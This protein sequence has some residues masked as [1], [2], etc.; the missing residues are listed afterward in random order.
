[1]EQFPEDDV[2][3]KDEDAHSAPLEGVPEL[4]KQPIESS[5]EGLGETPFSPLKQKLLDGLGAVL[6]G[7]LVP[8]YKVVE[9]VLDAVGVNTGRESHADHERIKTDYESFEKLSEETGEFFSDLI[10]KGLRKPEGDKVSR[11]LRFPVNHSRLAQDNEMIPHSLVSNRETWKKEYRENKKKILENTLFGE[12]K[13]YESAV[14]ESEISEGSVLQERSGA[15]YQGGDTNLLHE[16]VRNEIDKERNRNEARA[17]LILQNVATGESLSFDSL[18]PYGW[19]FAP[20]SLNQQG[21]G[22]SEAINLKELEGASLP[23]SRFF[24]RH[25]TTHGVLHGKEIFYGN[26]SEEGAVLSLFHEI[27]HAWQ[28]EYLDKDLSGRHAFEGLYKDAAFYFRYSNVYAWKT[29]RDSEVYRDARVSMIKNLESLGIEPYFDGIAN[30]FWTDVPVIEDG[31]L[32]IKSLDFTSGEPRDTYYPV[33]SERMTKALGGYVADERDAWAH[34]LKTMR[35]LRTK[36]LDIAP[37]LTNLEKVKAKIDP[38]LESYQEGLERE[39]GEGDNSVFL[40]RP[41]SVETLHPEQ[42]D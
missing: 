27:A 37:E 24:A 10:P 26:L 22:K 21:E 16:R 42:L 31:V 19:Q 39:M 14:K 9:P 11:R 25:K 13:P 34:A 38:C 5:V 3:K 23:P 36:G 12:R 40:K 29:G 2:S 18:L 41:P 28:A 32:N 8:T 33:R 30:N 1:M 4:S 15:I 6:V 7:V 20:S 17:N 35:F